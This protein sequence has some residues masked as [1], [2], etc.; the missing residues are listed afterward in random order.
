[1]A[2]GK[3]LKKVKLSKP[4][5][6]EGQFA[7]V[8][9][10]PPALALPPKASG[11]SPFIKKLEERRA[12]TIARIKLQK[13]AAGE[14]IPPP[15]APQDIVG[16]T[17]IEGKTVAEWHA[18]IEAFCEGKRLVNLTHYPAW[19][20]WAARIWEQRGKPNAKSVLKAKV[21]ELRAEAEKLIN[22]ASLDESNAIECKQAGEEKKYAKLMTQV[23]K[24]RAKA[25]ELREQAS[26]LIEES[27]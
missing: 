6:I 5:D 24:K 12:A 13:E 20:T 16:E 17:V 8:P 10:T 11:P 3:R 2:M 23:E 7:V 19:T 15:I 26:K 1:M 25:Q 9:P 14:R 22:F 27:P 18:D 4:G 21:T